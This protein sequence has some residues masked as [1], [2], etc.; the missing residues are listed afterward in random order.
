MPVDYVARVIYLVCEHNDPGE[1]YHLA[2]TIETPHEFYIPRMLQAVGVSGV[3]RVDRVPDDKN[4]LEELYYKSVGAL[5]TPYITCEPMC[6]DTENLRHLSNRFGLSCPKLDE[7]ALG[8]LMGY[9]RDRNFGL[10]LRP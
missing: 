4:S 2:N 7:E 8:V 6:F 9:A 5:Y 1:S 3:T 10:K